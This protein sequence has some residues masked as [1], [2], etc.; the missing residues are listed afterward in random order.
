VS[1]LGRGRIRR[2]LRP[3]LLARADAVMVNGESGARYARALGAPDAKT[4]RVHQAVDVAAFD[5]APERA[6]DSARRLLFVG[7]PEPRKGLRPFL[8]HLAGWA[9]EHPE[10]Q[11]E[12]RVAG[13]DAEAWDALRLDL[14]DNLVV[15]WLGHVPYDRMPEIYADAGILAF[16]TL[17]D[18]W[19]LVTN[20]AMA[21]G[22]PVLG[23]VY[24]QAVEELVEDGRTGWT[25]RPDRADDC[26][27]AI[28]RALTASQAELAAMRDAC[29][30]RVAGF[31][32]EAVAE[33]MLA[34]VA[35]A[36]RNVS[37]G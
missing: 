27:D 7:S 14:P 29:R 15:R 25:F 21:A 23:S 10:R 34:A 8:V 3:W 35:F 26:R 1:E 4:F 31:S 37:P 12:L 6:R 2:R 18:E 17:A 33:R 24:S 36:A 30:E 5:A 28:G 16:P 11:V 9:A 32:L 20:E 22:L 13:A 19:G